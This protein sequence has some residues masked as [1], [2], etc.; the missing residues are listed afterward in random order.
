MCV[1][2]FETGPTIR[3]KSRLNANDTIYISN[4]TI[5]VYYLIFECHIGLSSGSCI[6]TWVHVIG[7]FAI[8]FFWNTAIRVEEI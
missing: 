7:S 3:G 6:S 5:K 4:P 1:I 2:V 8:I